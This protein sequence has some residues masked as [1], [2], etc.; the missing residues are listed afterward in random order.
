M[1]LIV[2]LGN[3]GKKYQNTRHNAGFMAI[4]VL[5][6]EQNLLWQKSRKF[7]A[8]LALKNNQFI[9][10][11]PQTFMNNSGQAVKAI[12]DYYKIKTENIW[13][14]CDDIDLPLGK[15]RVRRKGTSGGHNG[16]ESILGNLKSKNFSRIKVGIQTENLLNISAEKFV[17]ANF[18][19]KEQ[20][21]V[22]DQI[23]K[24]TAIIEKG[25]EA[26]VLDITT[27]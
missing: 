20:V 12:A 3:P 9:L 2:G 22:S 6:S 10:V 13:V 23:K 18:R 7:S 21:I 8:E 27:L 16:L 5:A 24:V 17:L 19:Q 26:G 15:I 4:D 1:F 11:K 25:V 14:V